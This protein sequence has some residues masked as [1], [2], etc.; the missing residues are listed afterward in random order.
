MNSATKSSDWSPD[1]FIKWAADVG[2]STLEVIKRILS[3]RVIVE[4]TFNTA[5]SILSLT[6]SHSKERIEEASREALSKVNSP[7]YKH[8][9]AIL[10]QTKEKENTVSRTADT[11]TV[12]AKGC[13]LGKDYFKNTGVKK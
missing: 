9:K 6:K 5:L 8:I 3:S 4:Q 2:P 11:N 10:S 1:R 7:R 13:L 12:K